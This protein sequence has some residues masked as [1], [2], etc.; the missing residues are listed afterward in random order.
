VTD[1]STELREDVRWDEPLR[2]LREESAREDF[3][4][5]LVEED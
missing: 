1:I 2:V 4:R 3:Y 5:T